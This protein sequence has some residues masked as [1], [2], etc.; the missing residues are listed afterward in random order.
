MTDIKKRAASALGGA[1]ATAA[2]PLGYGIV[3]PKVLAGAAAL[4]AVGG[5]CGVNVAG[6]VKRY[7][8]KRKAPTPSE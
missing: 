1:V 7:A 4:G 8:A 6:M 3:N 5:L 2:V